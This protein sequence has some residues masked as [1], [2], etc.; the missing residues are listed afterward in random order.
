MSNVKQWLQELVALREEMAN[1]KGR[2]KAE[3]TIDREGLAT[4]PGS[5]LGAEKSHDV[6]NVVWRTD[7]LHG[8]ISHDVL[9]EEAI[10]FFPKHMRRVSVHKPRIDAVDTDTLRGEFTGQIGGE[11]FEGALGGSQEPHVRGY[12]AGRR[13]LRR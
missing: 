10:H 4:D 6:G 9:G 7:P 13:C 11:D 1:V 12:S 3:A 2:G 5:V 8:G